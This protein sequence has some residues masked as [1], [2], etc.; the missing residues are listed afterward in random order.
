MPGDAVLSALQ[1][2]TDLKA[3]LPPAVQGNATIETAEFRDGGAGR[4]V[5]GLG[6][7]IRITNEQIQALSKQVKGRMGAVSGRVFGF[8]VPKYQEYRE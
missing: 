5:V 4:L 1:K 8:A 3:T 2:G 6:G 7:E